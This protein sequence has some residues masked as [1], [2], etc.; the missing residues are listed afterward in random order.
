M[1]GYF[2]GY[3]HRDNSKI[4]SRGYIGQYPPSG[5]GGILVKTPIKRILLL[6][7]G[8]I[9]VNTPPREEGVYW[10]IPPH[11][12]KGGNLFFSNYNGNGIGMAR[13]YWKNILLILRGWGNTSSSVGFASGHQRYCL[14]LSGFGGYFPIPP[15]HAYAIPP[16]S[17]LSV[18]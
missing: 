16:I 8:G 5:G 11:C 10:S 18:G 14:N 12:E 7:R 4:L 6:S 3:T 1:A 13:R 17:S 9:L 15:R 2:P